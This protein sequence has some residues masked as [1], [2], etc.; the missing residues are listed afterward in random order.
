[1]NKQ[2]THEECTTCGSLTGNAGAG[3]GSLFIGG[4]G[5]LC[6]DCYDALNAKREN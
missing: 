4:I 6:E 5:P 3:D 1:M 2:Q